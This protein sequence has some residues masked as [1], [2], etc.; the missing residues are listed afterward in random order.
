MGASSQGL[1]N[2]CLAQV[3]FIIV[4]A[5]NV[6]SN[7][8]PQPQPQEQQQ[9]QERQRQPQSQPSPGCLVQKLKGFCKYEMKRREKN[10]EAQSARRPLASQHLVSTKHCSFHRAE[11]WTLP[12][13]AVAR[14]PGNWDPAAHRGTRPRC[15]LKWR[16]QKDVLY[17]SHR[18]SLQTCSC[19]RSLVSTAK[20]A[21]CEP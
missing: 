19:A 15:S 7:E 13:L 2:R 8:Q 20:D 4:I 18:S 12:E 21:F 16:K 9:E 17:A 1:T 14:R 11:R 3:A 10:T 5:V 6:N